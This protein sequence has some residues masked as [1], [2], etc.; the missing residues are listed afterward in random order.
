MGRVY[1]K[2]EKNIKNEE[3]IGCKIIIFYLLKII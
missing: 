3:K 1:K 2:F